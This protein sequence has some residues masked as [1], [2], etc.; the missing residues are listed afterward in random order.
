[1]RVGYDFSHITR[2]GHVFNV[3]AT[4]RGDVY[5]IN[6]AVDPENPANR[7]TGKKARIFP[8]ISADWRYPLMRP[9]GERSYLTVEPIVGFVAAP[10]INRQW[11]IPNED[12]IDQ[13]Y[14]ETNLF[15]PNR[16]TGEDRLEGG[17]RINYG[18]KVGLNDAFSGSSWL[19]LGQSYRL[20][21]DLSFPSG[22]GLRSRLSDPIAA[23]SINPGRYWDI[24]G[25]LRV[26][27]DKLTRVRQVDAQVNAGPRSFR[28]FLGYILLQDNLATS[29]S[30]GNR[31][32]GRLGFV[33]RP[34]EN[35]VVTAWGARDLQRGS[36][37]ELRAKLEYEDECF[38]IG[39]QV[40]RRYFTDKEI[41]PDNRIG[42]RIV[43][44]QTTDTTF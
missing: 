11:Q 32:E 25:R 9:I 16:N 41:K 35:W 30:L 36:T 26:D 27:K 44:K 34:H 3:L 10:S 4:L 42:V 29:T 5:D 39:I 13:V 12:S 28:G 33:A 40:A 18:F 24:F 1:V 17:Q 19:F 15:S 2:D 38:L 23:L 8:Q 7:F 6:N 22:S 14:D 31:S 21:R 37:R 43:F 20:Q